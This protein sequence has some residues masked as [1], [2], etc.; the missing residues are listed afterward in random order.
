MISHWLKTAARIGSWRHKGVVLAGA[1]MLAALPAAV[2]SRSAQ[3]EVTRDFQK[4]LT[5]GAGQSVSVD[6]RFGEVR[7]HG[8]S[9]REVKINA[10]IRVQAGSRSDSEAFA[11][12]IRIEVEQTGE[13][14]RIRTVYPEEE[15]RWFSF[16]RRSSYSVNYDIGMPADAPL[17]VKNNFGSVETTGVHGAG[18]LENS[19]GSLTVR[20]AGAARLNNSFGSIELGGASGNVYLSDNNGSVQVFDVKGTLEIRNRFGSISAR[21]IQGS[22]TITGGNGALE[23]TD[24]GAASITNSFGS[25]NA[26][27]IRGDLSVHDNNGNVEVSTIAGG[28]AITNSFGNVSFNDVHGRVNCTTHNGRVRG[29]ASGGGAVS[30]RDSFGN[31]ELDT[32]VGALDAETSNGKITV[33]DARSSVTLKSSFG[34]IEASNIPKG[35][36]AVTGNGAL[37]LTDIGG[38]TYAKTS[39]GS[40]LVERIGGNLTAENSNGSV[41][42][43]NVKGDTAVDTSFASVTLEAIGGRIRVDNQ[44]G[45]ISVSASRPAS[46]C[47][48]ISLKT[49]FSS[50]RVGIPE[51]LGYNLTARTSFGRVNTELP[52]TATGSMGGET[53]NGTIGSGGCQLQLTNSNG[54]IEITKAR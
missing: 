7:I 12:K 34:A 15:K 9:G 10:T 22:A 53:L 23:L 31:I 37:D 21:N 29:S 16:G 4:S 18:D 41:T 27:N 24:S 5:L 36:S 25:V 32:I 1:M 11:D 43:R 38:D 26:H 17:R 2:A 50:I 44:N 14:V 30:I 33:H 39:F 28:I 3:E 8:E 35:V 47:R 54:N 51:G 52:I 40:I 45:A 48:D 19:H 49:S 13:G 46:G 42:A 20:D 6:H